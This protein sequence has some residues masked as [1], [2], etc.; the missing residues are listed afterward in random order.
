MQFKLKWAK[1][2]RGKRGRIKKGIELAAIYKYTCKFYND[3]AEIVSNTQVT[4]K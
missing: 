2:S 4:H 1:S 3:A